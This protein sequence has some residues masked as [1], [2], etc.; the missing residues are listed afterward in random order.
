MHYT[1]VAAVVPYSMYTHAVTPL[2]NMKAF[3]PSAPV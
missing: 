1:C 3:L 2:N